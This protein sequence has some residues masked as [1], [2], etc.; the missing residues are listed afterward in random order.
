MFA[1]EGWLMVDACDETAPADLFIEA[2][3]TSLIRIEN[4][5]SKLNNISPSKLGKRMATRQKRVIMLMSA[6]AMKRYAY[7]MEAYPDITQRVPQK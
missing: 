2:L 6:T 3:E 5:N 1:P 4:K 7:F